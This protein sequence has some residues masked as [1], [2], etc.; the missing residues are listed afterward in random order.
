VGV[1]RRL[2]RALFVLFLVVCA[3]LSLALVAG[4]IEQ[5]IFR[6]RAE[7]LLAE[8]QSLELRKTPW[9]EALVKFQHWGA[10]RKFDDHCDEHKCSFQIT[11]DYTLLNYLMSRNIF[12]RLDDYLRWRFKL[13]YGEGEGPFDSLETFL[14]HAYLRVGGHPARVRATV[15]MRDG[16]VWSEG[17]DLAIATYAQLEPGDHWAVWQGDYTLYA[18]AGSRPRIESL[19]QSIVHADYAIGRPGGCEICVE[20]WVTFTPY[21]DPSDIHRLLQFDLSCL[22]RWNPCHSQID[23]MPVAWTQYLV[24]LPIQIAQRQAPPCNSTVIE[25]LG[26]DSADILIG[27][28]LAIHEE[29]YSSGYRD[30]V[31]RIRVLKKLKGAADWNVGET[32][33][34]S[35]LFTTREELARVRP[36]L[37]LLLFG[38]RNYSNEVTIDLNDACPLLPANEGNLNLVRQGIDQDYSAADKPQ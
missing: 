18:F 33:D 17:Y 8:V 22:T 9:P 20:G 37:S 34:V 15:G 25:S 28:V 3:L 21:A 23:I 36:G 35:V 27:E 13:S 30:G 38:G 29:V 31:A 2:R 12:D 4:Q 16:V 14:M 10:N 11:L 6:R 24:E 26:R 5:R 7:R 32:H 1:I 19:G